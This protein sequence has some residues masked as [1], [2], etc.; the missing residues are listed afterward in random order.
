MQCLKYLMIYIRNENVLIKLV[1]I[2]KTFVRKKYKDIYLNS[3]YQTFSTQIVWYVIY[4]LH[5]YE[6]RLNLNRSLMKTEISD[7]ADV[8]IALEWNVMVKSYGVLA[9]L[10][11]HSQPPRL[12]LLLVDLVHEL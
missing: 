4:L 11:G 9:N 5:I 8:K 2:L 3:I 7:T 6:T 12:H 1:L 10:L